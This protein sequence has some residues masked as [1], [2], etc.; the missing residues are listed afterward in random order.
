MSLLQEA[1]AEP[2]FVRAML[3]SVL[4]SISCGIVGTFVV[5]RRMSSIS[6]GLSH[7][8][9][10]GV[11]MAYLLGFSPLFGAMG[12]SLLCALGVAYVHRH[13]RD[14][15]DSLIAI[16]WSVGMALGV[17]FI[18]LKPGVAPDLSG[19]L[20]GN[21]LFVPASY[22][23]VAVMADLIVLG[24]VVFFYKELHAVSFDEEFSE[25]IGVPVGFFVGLLLLLSALVVVVLMRMVG[26]VLTI[27]LLTTPAV[28]AGRWA[29]TLPMMM[30]SS[31]LITM[32]I[33]CGGL[34]AAF[35]LSVRMGINVPTGPLIVIIGALLFV[36]SAV[37]S[38]ER[39]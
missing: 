23:Q 26:A 37:L 35:W 31:I 14:T 33:S 19:Y 36:V 4:V 2:F 30:V 16:V 15:L 11:G 20:F 28:I 17:L 29:R 25:I 38:Q 39:K 24:C 6:G 10:G 12:F 5:I 32:F 34:L 8:A 27:A 18:S 13:S 21:I 7:A 22:L 1:F 3:A 9:F